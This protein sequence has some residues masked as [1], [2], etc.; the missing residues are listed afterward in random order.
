MKG[1]QIKFTGDEYTASES[2]NRVN[3]PQRANGTRGDLPKS[4]NT[5]Q[6]TPKPYTDRGDQTGHNDYKPAEDTQA[7]EVTT[8][9]AAAVGALLRR[10]DIDKFSASDILEAITDNSWR[11]FF[12]ILPKVVHHVTATDPH[13]GGIFSKALARAVE[14]LYDIEEYRT[15]LRNMYSLLYDIAYNQHRG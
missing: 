6:P 12:Y 2:R 9:E 3:D 13:L 5:E 11:D 7:Q 1:K 10:Y 15:T 14:T 8:E 4:D